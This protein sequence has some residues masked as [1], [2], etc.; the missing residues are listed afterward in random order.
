MFGTVTAVQQVR[1]MRG[2][3]QSHLMR[4]R[5]DASGQEHYWVVKFRNNPQ[6]VRVLAN[7][8]L[9]TR[10]AEKVGLPVP[11]TASVEVSDWLIENSPEL[12][13]NFF[14]KQEICSSGLQFGA[15]YVVDPKV[16][17]VYDYIP[18][19]F[20]ERVRNLTDFV[21]ILCLDKWTCNANGRQAVYWKKGREQ[22]YTVTF[23]DQGYCFNAG[24]WNFPDAPLRGVYARN[25]VYAHV[26]GWGSFE[27]WLSRI[28]GLPIEDL[29]GI[30]ETVPPE[31][32]E[33]DD[34]GLERL[35]ETLWKRRERVPELIH[36]FRMSSRD[37]FPGWTKA[38]SAVM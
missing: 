23:I 10:I 26:T 14:G 32:Y 19:Q 30:A 36:D 35:V 15:R 3:A 7:E 8:L 17:Q 37:P 11:V 33:Y 27:P 1:R 13:H 25:V 9:A 20:L 38:S 28:Q 31:W 6:H 2:G 16:G 4:C 34:A 21:G 18:E 22:K 29:W 12:R 24:E 5:D